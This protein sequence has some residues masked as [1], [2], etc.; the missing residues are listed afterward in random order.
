MY[1]CVYC[2]EHMPPW[3]LK[4]RLQGSVGSYCPTIDLPAASS[5]RSPP[6]ALTTTLQV[7]V[8]ESHLGACP[9]SHL[10]QCPTGVDFRLSTLSQFI[11]WLDKTINQKIIH[12]RGFLCLHI[13]FPFFPGGPA[14]LPV[15][16]DLLFAFSH[17]ACSFSSRH[18]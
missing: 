8:S 15:H 2:R 18:F 10:L 13:T 14:S 9:A 6:A 12:P 11:C 1:L 4:T 3:V 5:N 16:E 7:G 17:M